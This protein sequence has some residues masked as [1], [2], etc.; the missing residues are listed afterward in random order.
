MILGRKKNEMHVLFQI[1][2]PKYLTG[3]IDF[4]FDWRQD[5]HVK[6]PDVR[7][8]ECASYLGIWNITKQNKIICLVLIYSHKHRH[9]FSL[10]W[11][12]ILIINTAERSKN[13][14]RKH[15]KT[16]HKLSGRMLLGLACHTLI[17]F[18]RNFSGQFLK[19]VSVKI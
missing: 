13:I 16:F 5:Q 19:Y 4:T 6:C 11:V 18:Q 8:S 12:V 3:I 17:I 10:S 9:L 15:S 2:L 1:K 14:I 7:C